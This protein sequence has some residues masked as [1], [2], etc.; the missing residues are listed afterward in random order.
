MGS[1]SEEFE[2]L[3]KVSD[4]M[5]RKFND[6]LGM[7]LG[8]ERPVSHM[9][10]FALLKACEAVNAYCPKQGSKH[11]RGMVSFV[12]SVMYKDYKGSLTE[13]QILAYKDKLFIPQPGMLQYWAE[14]NNFDRIEKNGSSLDKDDVAGKYVLTY[15]PPFA[16]S[17][18]VRNTDNIEDVTNKH[19]YSHAKSSLYDENGNAVQSSNP[20]AFYNDNAHDATVYAP[21]DSVSYAIDYKKFGLS[22]KDIEDGLAYVGVGINVMEPKI[23]ETLHGLSDCNL[24]RDDIIY[25]WKNKVDFSNSDN[26][27]KIKNHMQKGG[28][29]DGIL[30]IKG[31]SINKS[32]DYEYN[33][34]DY[35][36]AI[37]PTAPILYATS[38]K[39]HRENLNDEQA[40]ELRESIG[41]YNI[42]DEKNYGKV[43]KNFYDK[44]SSHVEIESSKE[45]MDYFIMN[46]LVPNFAKSLLMVGMGA[47]NYDETIVKGVKNSSEY[48][49]A[50]VEDNWEAYNKAVDAIDECIKKR[51]ENLVKSDGV[52]KIVSNVTAF[53]DMDR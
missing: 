7:K 11:S 36:C 21:Y 19:W 31:L 35:S 14:S 41:L 45:M 49:K 52:K 26:L 4:L 39:I 16:S 42:Y 12:N 6:R 13:E 18:V 8:V 32:N 44:Y 5:Y 2:E 40:N 22:K 46:P 15:Y 53:L 33:L 38:A 30:K 3:K 24:S 1:F 37:Q 47:I 10:D 43:N 17:W 34:Q 29:K 48:I 20:E 50:L 23:Q 28:N 27:D 51:G 25:L 9:L